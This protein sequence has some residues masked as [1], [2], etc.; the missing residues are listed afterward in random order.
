MALRGSNARLS[1]FMVVDRSSLNLIFEGIKAA[2]LFRLQKSFLPATQP[3]KLRNSINLHSI[4]RKIRGASQPRLHFQINFAF[5][6]HNYNTTTHQV[7]IPLL[8]IAVCGDIAD[9]YLRM[10]A[11]ASGRTADG[12]KKADVEPNWPSGKEATPK[13]AFFFLTILSNMK[14]KPDV[15]WDEVAVKAGYSNATT[16]KVRFGQIKRK[17]GFGDQ[18][19]AAASRASGNGSATPKKGKKSSEVGSGTN[20]SPSKVEKKTPVKRTPNKAKSPVKVEEDDENENDHMEMDD[21]TEYP[22]VDE[23]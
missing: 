1:E 8:L 13:D 6:T 7:Y 15:N 21:P 12:A 9:A 22:E 4:K 23:N 18:D 14:N 10:S 5:P 3:Q 11:P 2:A 20:V 17:L 19:T 16:A